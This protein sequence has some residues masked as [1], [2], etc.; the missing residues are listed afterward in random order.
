[1]SKNNRIFMYPVI[2]INK[3]KSTVEITLKYM[4]AIGLQTISKGC[5]Y[6]IRTF[7]NL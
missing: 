1:M 3:Q 6:I 4:N 2:I 5:F 7:C